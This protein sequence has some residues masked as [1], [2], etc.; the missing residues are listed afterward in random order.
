MALESPRTDL[1][2]R[3]STPDAEALPWTDAEQ[4]LRD[5]GEFWV[6]TVRPTGRPHV[7]PLIAVWLDSALYFST[8]KTNRRR[9]ATD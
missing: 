4:Q 6:S 7:V 3:F 1:D 8:V 2:R 5:A 9:R